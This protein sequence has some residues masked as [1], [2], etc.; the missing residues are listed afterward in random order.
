MKL[1]SA[2]VD[3]LPA[4]AVQRIAT[5]KRR[6]LAEGRDVIDL[7][8]GD[9]DLAPPEIAVKTLAEALK[10]PRMSRYAFQTGL[11]EFRQAVA[12]YMDR[13]FNVEIDPNTEMLPLLGS[14]DG[15]AHLPL[16]LLDPGDLCLVPEPGY[17]PYIGGAMLAGAE[18]HT[19]RLRPERGFLV[20]LDELHP[21]LLDKLELIFLNY[22]NNPTTGV[23][24]RDYL[25]RVVQLC[26]RH[27]IV[28]AYDNP[29]C[30]LVFEGYHAPSIFEIPGAREVAIE[31]LSMSKSFCMTGW[32]IGWALGRPEL[33]TALQ[34]VKTY[35]DTGP[36][37]AVQRAA[38][39]VLDQAD[40]LVPK[41]SEVFRRRRDAG[42]EALRA[43]G[44]EITRPRATM[45]L[46]VPL[47]AGVESV[48][49]AERLLE[50]Q[51]VVVLPG[52]SFGPGGEGYFRVAL[53]VSE[54]RFAEAAQRIGRA[55]EP[56]ERTA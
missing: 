33:I 11:P 10:D 52:A 4:Y 36:F 20:D 53:T 15:L 46:W 51:A 47:P 27:G 50:E 34:H 6:L 37:L 5:I 42:V 18:I 28:L 23:A 19:Y 35:T 21:N 39:A 30:E 49:F 40:R 24:T 32:R 3:R 13:R 2:R 8:A 16:A 41:I 12:G 26:R 7:G 9:A 22:P 25:V 38:A 54:A 44:L 48:A 56:A 55:L 29:Y 31:F 1:T 45:Y 17:A 14:K 43:V